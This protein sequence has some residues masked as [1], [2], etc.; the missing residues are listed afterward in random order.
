[1]KD[2]MA[3]GDPMIA[4]VG[5]A[6]S[7]RDKRSKTRSDAF[8]G[9]LQRLQPQAPGAPPGEERSASLP[10]RERDD[11]SF[12]GR[13]PGVR[14]ARRRD[15]RLPDAPRR[16]RRKVHGRGA[17]RLPGRPSGALQDEETSEV[18]WTPSIKDVPVC[19]LST[20][21]I[22]GGNSGSPILNGKGD[23]I[24]VIFDGNLEAVSADYYFMP[25]LTRAISVDG[26]YILFVLDKFSDAK[27][28]L[29]EMTVR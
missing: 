19:F 17:V 20:D 29:G 27:E 8:D 21:D 4:F 7:C 15:V 16:R 12:G 5:R 6:R 10:R 25:D 9:A 28:L 24:G 2:L 1:M 13:S 11:A 14:A 18:T 22:T 23:L 3:L 26:R